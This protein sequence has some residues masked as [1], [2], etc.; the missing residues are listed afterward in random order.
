[1]RNKKI[2]TFLC[3]EAKGLTPFKFLIREFCIETKYLKKIHFH[4]DYKIYIKIQLEF[5]PSRWD[6]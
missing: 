5:Y 3:I 6:E 1:M 2:R 4:K